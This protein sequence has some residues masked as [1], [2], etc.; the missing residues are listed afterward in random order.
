MQGT[1][2]DK[3]RAKLKK[4]KC[5]M[6]GEY[7]ECEDYRNKKVSYDPEIEKHYHCDNCGID[8]KI[9]Y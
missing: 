8:L 6:C 7:V 5:P 2:H 3:R 4:I 9:N 1:E